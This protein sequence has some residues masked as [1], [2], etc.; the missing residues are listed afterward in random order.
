MALYLP[1]KGVYFDQIASGEKLEEY[2]LITPFWAKRLEGRSYPFIVL[3]RGYP[4]GGGIFGS[5]RLLRRWKGYAVKTITHPHFRP[6]PVEVFAIDVSE[7]IHMTP[8]SMTPGEV[9][10]L[11]RAI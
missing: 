4:Q 7:P 9:K 10:P 8:A 5:T 2:R 6:D 3:T 1:L 11:R